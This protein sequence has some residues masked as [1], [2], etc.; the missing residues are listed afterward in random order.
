MIVA[1]NAVMGGHVSI[2]DHAVIMVNGQLVRSGSPAAIR[3][4]VVGAYLG[5]DDLEAPAP[6]APDGTS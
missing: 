3:A 5:S 6:P 4:E 1:N 2:A